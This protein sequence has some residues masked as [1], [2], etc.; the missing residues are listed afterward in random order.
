VRRETIFFFGAQRAQTHTHTH[1]SM[2]RSKLFDWPLARP[3][4]R[5]SALRKKKSANGK[6]TASSKKSA[7]AKKRSRR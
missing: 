7:T 2:A 3:S 5:R 1:A 4:K 6:K